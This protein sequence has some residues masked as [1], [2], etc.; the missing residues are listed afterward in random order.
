MAMKELTLNGRTYLTTKR[1]AEITGYTT[2]YVGQLARQEKVD[3]QLVGRNWYIGEDSI[4]KH[5]FGEAEVSIR[6]EENEAPAP[7]LELLVNSVEDEI[8]K[9]EEAVPIHE[10]VLE[11]VVEEDPLTNMQSAWQDWYKE[12]RSVPS[13][14]EEVFLRREDV[15]SSQ[16]KEDSEEEEISITRKDAVTQQEV[17]EEVPV[18]EEEVEEAQEAIPSPLPAK[19]SW[20]G[21]GLALTVVVTVLFIGTVTVA[22]GYVLSKN[23]DT[24][25]ANVY[26][27]VQDYFLGVQRVQ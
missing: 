3:A 18:A 24:P 9:E 14:E 8:K 2:D 6:K 12:Q 5:K 4:K 17:L 7:A 19:R 16:P 23:T 13:D 27:G 21:T 15:V 1:A 25:I 11:G 20:A 22:T 10:E 26:Q